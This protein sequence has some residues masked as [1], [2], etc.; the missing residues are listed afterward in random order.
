MSADQEKKFV[1]KEVFEN[2]KAG[3]QKIGKV[4]ERLGIL[5]KIKLTSEIYWCGALRLQLVC[6]KPGI[7]ENEWSIDTDIVM[8]IGENEQLTFS[9]S[10]SFTQKSMSTYEYVFIDWYDMDKFMKDKNLFVE[11]NVT[12]KKSIGVDLLPKKLK[13][14]DD[15]VAKMFSDVVL[16]VGDQE[17]H[18]NKMYLASHSTYFEIL[19]LGNFE[20]SKKSIIEL[21]DIDP[22]EFQKFLEVLY[23]ESPINDHTV[24]GILKLGDMYDAKTAI[25]RCD[26]FL[27]LYSKISL[28]EKFEIAVKYKLNKLTMKCISKM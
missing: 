6:S 24:A 18:V 17:F 13:I 23:G 4:E 5:W 15:D 1:I 27:A 8:K 25:K 2:V 28:K 19:F 14:F 3:E 7:S 9:K 12:I 10:H 11:F 20:E 22:D 26:E 21:K 16:M